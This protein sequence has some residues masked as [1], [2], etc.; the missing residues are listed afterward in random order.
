L[1]SDRCTAAAANGSVRADPDGA[2]MARLPDWLVLAI[3]TNGSPWY[4][5]AILFR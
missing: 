3:G 5:S 1:L 4:L 2:V